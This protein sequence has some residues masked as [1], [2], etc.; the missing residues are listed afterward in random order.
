[1]FITG[2]PRTGS[3]A[4]GHMLALDS[5]TRSLRGWEAYEPCPPPGI[6]VKD[7][8]RIAANEKRTEFISQMAPGIVE[9]IPLNPH[10]PDECY[11]LLDLSFACVGMDG[12]YNVPDY[13]DWAMTEN[14]PELDAAYRYHR[15]VLKLLQWK[16]PAT[17]WVLRTP[18]HSTGI[19]SLLKAYPDAR[20]IWTHREPEKV[21][22]S[23]CSLIYQAREIFLTN[24]SPLQLGPRQL[25]QWSESI[26]R[27]MSAREQIGEARFFDIYH[28][29]IIAD[30]R[31]VHSQSVSM[32]G[33]GVWRGIFEP[34]QRLAER[35]SHRSAQACPGFFWIESRRSQAPLC[36]VHR[37][38]W[39]AGMKVGI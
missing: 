38:I 34:P 3:T 28:R 22:P 32:V 18:L 23:I 35:K 2:L 15:R 7:D 6:D 1:M 36:I 19:N 21:L 9:A 17:R 26:R 10:A 11:T 12:R 27:L 20:F 39:S 31:T 4:L 14:L 33:V 16:T 29:E 8:P 13:E 25:N 5:N 37:A 24:P 30:P